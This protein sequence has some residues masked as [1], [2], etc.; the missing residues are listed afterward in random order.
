MLKKISVDQVRL[1]MYIQ[2]FCSTWDDSPFWRTSLKMETRQQLQDLQASTV[3]EV[4]I[5]TDKGLDAA[6]RPA[7][8]NPEPAPE[9]APPLTEALRRSSFSDEMAEAKNICAK[10]KTAVTTMFQEARMGKALNA[11]QATGLVDEIS[12]SVMRNPD[13]LIGLARLKNK[14]DY[15]YMHSVA[16]CA[17]MIAL[18]K[19]LK[20]DD[21]QIRDAGMAGL[22]HDIGKMAIPQEI[23]D[24][25]GKLTDA[26]F[27]TVKGHPVHGHEML[28]QG[29]NVSAAALEVCLHHHERMDGN[30]YPHRLQGEQIS[31]FARM[32]AVCDVYDAITSN[33][34]YKAGWEP[35]ESLRR[36]AE[37]SGSHFDPA[38]FQAFVK[39]LGIY[40]TGSLVKLKSGRVGVVIE[41]CEQSLLTPRVK[42][43][44]SLKSNTYIAPEIVDLARVDAH[45]SIH[46]L[47]DAE[48][49]GL[50][51]VQAMWTA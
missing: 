27:L 3:Q 4:W 46:E 8:R 49:L 5:N 20:L 13:A 28:L 39:C 29:E 14:D 50:K 24:K 9:S 11:A 25:P 30:G 16:V 43:F 41:Q 18:A 48:Q 51:N 42:V 44:F 47:G 2:K 36:M 15:T 21:A 45:D 35:A 17:L 6:P 1:G 7:A 19:K 12:A 22:L 40:P 26:E 33:R 23:L 31:L 32:G 34:A 38:I 10:G 37:W